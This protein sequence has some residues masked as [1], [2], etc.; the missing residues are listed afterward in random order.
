[1]SAPIT[2][3]WN[4]KQAAEQLVACLLESVEYTMKTTYCLYRTEDLIEETGVETTYHALGRALRKAGFVTA[5]GEQASRTKDGCFRLWIIRQ[6]S[7][8][9][10]RSP[11]AAGIFY[12]E[13]RTK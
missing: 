7:E 10:R 4:P 3:P 8:Q 1:M 9:V 2:K 12:D 11:T 5:G 13:E 6:V